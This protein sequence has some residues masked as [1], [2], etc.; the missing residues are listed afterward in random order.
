[1]DSGGRQKKRIEVPL[2]EVWGLKKWRKSD[3]TP[4]AVVR[5][6]IELGYPG[7]WRARIGVASYR[8]VCDCREQ[9]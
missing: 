1:M 8:P 7:V 3:L 4:P 2:R 6:C 9:K 5:L